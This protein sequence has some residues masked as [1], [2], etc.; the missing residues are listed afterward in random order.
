M[1]DHEIQRI[2]AA[3]HQLRPDWP[4]SSVATLI[5]KNLADRPRRDVAVALAW[6]AC[7]TATSTPARVLETG[8]WWRAAGVEGTTRR[9]PFDPTTTCGICG[10]P[11]HRCNA[12]PH[13]GH[14]FVSSVAATRNARRHQAAGTNPEE[15]R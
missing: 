5:R 13:S 6:V 15:T 11:E 14:E 4:A 10:Q 8:P 2:A 12:N 1:N 9:E 3:A 7:E